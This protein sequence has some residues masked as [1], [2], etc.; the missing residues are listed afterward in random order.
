V[1]G[2]GSVQVVILQLFEELL[3]QHG[4]F[5]SWFRPRDVIMS[6]VVD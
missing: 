2:I 6:A 5:A 4:P 1:G 3:A